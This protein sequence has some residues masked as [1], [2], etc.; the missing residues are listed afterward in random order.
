M[1]DI[2]NKF[3]VKSSQKVLG[4]YSKEELI[5]LIKK[6]KV[7]IFAEVTEPFKIWTF[8]ENHEE[9]K[10]TIQS[11]NIQTRLT[12]FLTK[13]SRGISV[14]KTQTEK[15]TSS[16]KTPTQE[17][18]SKKT[19]FNSISKPKPINIKR[20]PHP[21]V[22][23]TQ[24]MTPQSTEE[25]IEEKLEKRI[26][27]AVRGLWKL[28]ILSSFFLVLF[29]GYNL[30]Y[31]P[32]QQKK[33]ILKNLQSKGK[34]YYEIGAFQQ[35]L[36]FFEQA[37]TYL[38]DEEKFSLAILLL[39]NNQIEKANLVKNE[40]VNSSLLQKS[41]GTLLKGLLAFYS[42]QHS[43]AEKSFQDVILQ[44]NKNTMDQARLN[45]ALLKLETR[46][47]NEFAME[48]KQLLNRSYQREIIWY[49]EALSFLK[50]NNISGLE[51]YLLRLG[52][53]ESR[54]PFE[55]RQEMFLLLSYSFMKAGKEAEQEEAITK[56]LNQDPYFIE[57]YSY[58][59]LIAKNKL[60]WT[61]IY[62][63]CREIFRSDPQK[64]LYQALY[65]LCLIKT[66]QLN[67]AKINI[68]KAK[69][70]EPENSLF[71]SLYAYLLIH[72]K[73]SS[74][75]IEQTLSLINY[76]SS[77]INKLPLIMKARFFEKD[78]YWDSALLV[79]KD[80]LNKDSSHLSAL[81]GIAFSSYQAGDTKTG[82][83]YRKKVLNEYPYHIKLL[84]LE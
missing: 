79:W 3:L 77:S 4:P 7:S 31:I 74:Q 59:P 64:S 14:S 84:S 24:K 43:L 45:L 46:Q 20:V 72:Q 51:S 35:A 37:K 29:V 73:E 39:H 11:M 60:N 17:N 13:V 38:S 28:I 6:G 23:R 61:K 68:E 67:Q 19:N 21:P 36:P 56:L 42:R 25:E 81:A 63:Y 30:F 52:L 54:K 18:T 10:K 9:F 16:Y 12:N 8:L 76:E 32:T 80:L 58:S 27:F 65:G 26:G 48:V 1:P 50:T 40:I 66:N 78:K 62:P 71:I 55:Y 33:E 34:K 2:K 57:E 82:G 75:K 69:N 44:K 41:E 47:Y 22:Q 83:F 49:L 5:T 70:Q 15:H 53:N